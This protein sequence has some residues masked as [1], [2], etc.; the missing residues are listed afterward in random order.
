MTGQA[1]LERG[2]RRVLA[3]YP[4]SFRRESEQE[5]L[6]VLMASAREGQQRVGLAESADLVRGGLR[7]RLRPG[8]PR[9]PSAHLRQEVLAVLRAAGRPAVARPNAASPS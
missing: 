6:A 2:Y 7:M 8:P 4:R 9:W 1:D 5:I 3:C